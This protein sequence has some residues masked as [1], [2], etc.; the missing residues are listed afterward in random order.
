MKEQH[1]WSLKKMTPTE[2]PCEVHPWS[3][4][5]GCK[6]S[7]PILLV[8][9]AHCFL[10]LECFIRISFFNFRN[11]YSVAVQET[12]LSHWDFTCSLWFTCFLV[13]RHMIW[14]PNGAQVSIES[15]DIPFT[16]F[17]IRFKRGKLIL[18]FLPK[19]IANPLKTY[20]DLPKW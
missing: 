8:I 9:T 20:F 13:C 6:G 5:Q 3:F 15:P 11:L 16:V 14:V 1:M 12:R 7:L 17:W 2:S 4:C 18:S 10:K 19:F